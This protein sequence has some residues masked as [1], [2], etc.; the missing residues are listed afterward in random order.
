MDPI[1][2]Y[3]EQALRVLRPLGVDVTQVTG[4]I[5]PGEKIG[6]IARVCGHPL[7]LPPQR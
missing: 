2:E 3:L 5:G 6:G 7:R 4:H 1:V